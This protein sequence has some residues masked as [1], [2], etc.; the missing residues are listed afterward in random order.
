[1]YKFFLVKILTILNLLKF[2]TIIMFL[3]T[4]NIQN[5]WAYL[6][7]ISMQNFA[8]LSPMVHSLSPTNQKLNTDFACLSS[9]STFHTKD[10]HEQKL[11]IFQRYTRQIHCLIKHHPI[12]AYLGTDTFLTSAL[13]G[14]EWSAS[15]P[16]HFAPGEKLQYPVDRSLGGPQ[17]K[18]QR[19]MAI[20]N[21]W[22]QHYVCFLLTS[23]CGHHVGAFMVGN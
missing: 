2:C 16:S 5:L 13:D 22:T 23:S 3:S 19:Y 6:W 9:C 1:M 10:L 7:S 14:D 17:K 20:Q 18:S 21:F 4:K 12:K 11:H 15:C 8:S